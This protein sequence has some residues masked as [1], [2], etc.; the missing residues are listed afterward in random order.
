MFKSKLV[1]RW[2]L[3]EEFLKNH[4]PILILSLSISGLVVGVYYAQKY[5]KETH[6]QY[7][8]EEAAIAKIKYKVWQTE[9][10]CYG[11]TFDEWNSLD[12]I[13]RG[14]LINCRRNCKESVATNQEPGFGTGVVTGAVGGYLLQKTLS[15]KK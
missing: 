11:L 12:Y 6:S 8:K 7:L 5:Q 10:P 14:T 13:Y 2:W 3:I 15:N 9:N 4:F 1:Y